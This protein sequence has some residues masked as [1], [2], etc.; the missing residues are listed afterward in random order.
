M[1]YANICK[2]S[3]W[4]DPNFAAHM[5]GD[6][7]FKKMFFVTK[8]LFGNLQYIKQT[9]YFKHDMLFF[10]KNKHIPLIV[11]PK[12]QKL[13]SLNLSIMAKSHTP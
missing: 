3:T 1:K 2:I 8:L 6:V 11:K 7:N 4:R 12:N 10:K 9:M 5:I 13:K